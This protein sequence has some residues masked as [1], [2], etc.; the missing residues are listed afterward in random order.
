MAIQI[1][2]S[3]GS[4]LNSSTNPLTNR[5]MVKLGHATVITPGVTGFD[6]IQLKN[7]TLD[8]NYLAASAPSPILHI[9]DDIRFTVTQY[10]EKF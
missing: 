4:T 10:P 6:V 1:K 3:D 8:T 5:N 9:V 7:A 2:K